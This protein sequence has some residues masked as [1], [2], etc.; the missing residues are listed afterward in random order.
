MQ[1]IPATPERLEKCDVTEVAVK[2][3]QISKPHYSMRVGAVYA[4][5]KV[6]S[7][8]D[9]QLHAAEGW[10]RD[11]ETGILGGKDPE[12]SRQCGKPDA[13]YAILSRIAAVDRCRY[14]EKCLGKISENILIKIM[15]E[16]LSLNEMALAI[17]VPN[18]DNAPQKE[19]KRHDKRRLA[20]MVDL[21]LEQLAE[22]Y[23]R[24]PDNLFMEWSAVPSALGE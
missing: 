10:A 20:G 14:V 2:L 19:A 23:S 6:G 16:C 12:T 11:Y 13:E 1:E 9:A 7:I 24:M 3:S 15:I 17:T 4:L 8:S 18:K 21:L 22:A 5:H